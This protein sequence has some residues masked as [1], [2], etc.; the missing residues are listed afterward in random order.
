MLPEQELGNFLNYYFVINHGN[1]WAD[2]AGSIYVGIASKS[3]LYGFVL[4]QEILKKI[5]GNRLVLQR[6]ILFQLFSPE[7]SL[8]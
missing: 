5:L 2:S 1:T 3:Y 7:K 8:A 4:I 6:S